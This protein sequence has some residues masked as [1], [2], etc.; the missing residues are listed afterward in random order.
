[1]AKTTA[2]AKAIAALEAE[3][4]VLDLAIAKLK[5]QLGAEAGK[6]VKTTDPEKASAE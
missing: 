2:L 1:V 4:A 6:K 3:K 5:A